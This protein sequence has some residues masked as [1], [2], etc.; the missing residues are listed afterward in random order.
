MTTLK[1][2]AAYPEAL[3]SKIEDLL[4]QQRLAEFLLNKYPT[5]HDIYND[6][7]LRDYCLSLKNQYA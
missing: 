4:K 5:R 2:L 3:T 1:Y 7:A 6:K